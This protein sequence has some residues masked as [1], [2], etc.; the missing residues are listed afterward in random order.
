MNGEHECNLLIFVFCPPLAT[1]HYTTYVPIHKWI[2]KPN[3]TSSSFLTLVHFLL[4]RF[5]KKNLLLRFFLLPQTE[6]KWFNS[7]IRCRCCLYVC[8][9]TMCFIFLVPHKFIENPEIRNRKRIQRYT[10]R[11]DHKVTTNWI[12][13][14]EL[15]KTTHFANKSYE[16]SERNEYECRHVRVRNSKESSDFFQRVS[17]CINIF[18]TNIIRFD[19][20]LS[21]HCL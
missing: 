7:W 9:M 17:K 2:P 4:L 8:T 20:I 14:N 5:R 3:A 11:K 18:W 19:K 10:E 12:E 1:L 6:L 15:W 13:N 16:C 21:F